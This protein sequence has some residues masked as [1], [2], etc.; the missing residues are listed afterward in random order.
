[1]YL[2]GIIKTDLPKA[3]INPTMCRTIQDLHQWLLTFF[4]KDDF[5]LDQP[6]TVETLTNALQNNKP[7]RVNITGFPLAILLGE[8]N[9]IQKNTNRFV[10]VLGLNLLQSTTDNLIASIASVLNA[11]RRPNVN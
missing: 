3:L 11:E 8:D 6:I 9:V 10:H 2:V 5:K 7:I 1:M 4:N